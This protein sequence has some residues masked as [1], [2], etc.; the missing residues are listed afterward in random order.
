[1]S[2]PTTLNECAGRI[3]AALN[4]SA[5]SVQEVAD[6]MQKVGKLTASRDLVG[7]PALF[8]G[9]LIVRDEVHIVQHADGRHEYI[10][11]HGMRWT[12]ERDASQYR[13]LVTIT[14]GVPGECVGM[15]ICVDDRE[16][17]AMDGDISRVIA[18]H[19]SQYADICAKKREEKKMAAMFYDDLGTSNTTAM[20]YTMGTSSNYNYGVTSLPKPMKKTNLDWL[21]G[22]IRKMRVKLT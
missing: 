22:E 14:G 10:G 11:H 19:V 20:T 2:L 12:I 18:Y 17:A 21:D 6:A 15:K 13:T 16:M 4:A 8:P 1:M 7:L 3:S 5:V 9:K